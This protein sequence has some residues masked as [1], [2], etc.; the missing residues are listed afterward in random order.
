M[1]R[2]HGYKLLAAGGLC[3]AA[4]TLCPGQAMAGSITPST[5]DATIAIGDSIKVVKKI[6]TDKGA[7]LVDFLFLADNTGSMGGVINNVKSVANQL[8]TDL[9]ATYTGAQFAVARYIGDPSET[10]P[11]NF[12]TAFNVLQK[13]T[14]SIANTVTGFN[15]WF[16]SGGGDYPEAGFYALQ[17]GVR[18]GASTCPG[19]GSTSGLCGGSGDSVGW[20][21]GARKVVLWFGDAPSH[22]TTVTMDN[23][24][25]ILGSENVALVALNSGPGA[26]GL[27]DINA[28]GG[29]TGNQASSVTGSLGSNGA[30]I[31]SFAT[32]PISSIL[33]TVED[34]VG[35]VTEKQNVSL[36][37]VGG[38][39]AGLD[40][41]FVCTDAQGCKD[42]TGGESREITMT[43][44]GLLT[45]DYNFNVESPGVLGAIEQDHIIVGEGQHAPGP[46]PL[47][48]ASA[49]L[50]WS[51]LLRRRIQKR[52]PLTT[53]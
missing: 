27:D 26:T 25:S 43:V 22:Q 33:S 8:L 48:G 39:P 19:L 34:A 44:K 47:L 30:L 28:D 42:V 24:K 23:I 7:G 38:A 12:A 11:P 32:V 51:R 41:S 2:H 16:A 15:S 20:R 14:T 46:L 21:S 10:A 52:E 53:T 17:Q 45:G 31:N 50:G 9:S 49:A 40:V 37:V 13:S 3:A 4:A 6:I 5:Y 18:N 1:P 36:A 35:K 29:Q